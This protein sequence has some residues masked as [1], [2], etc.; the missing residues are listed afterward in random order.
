MNVADYGQRLKKMGLGSLYELA[1]LEAKRN[2]SRW[3]LGRAQEMDRM[4]ALGQLTGTLM[5]AAKGTYQSYKRG[6]RR[7]KGQDTEI[8]PE[9]KAVM[10][11]MGYDDAQGTW[12][13]DVAQRFAPYFDL[14]RSKS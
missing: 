12:A 2:L 6:E 10:Q 14:F 7:A 5:G 4:G 11:E 1:D 13:W 9:V 3:E 8:S